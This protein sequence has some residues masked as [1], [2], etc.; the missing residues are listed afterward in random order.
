MSTA[1]EATVNLDLDVGARAAHLG[2]QE[3]DLTDQEF[4]LLVA[5]TMRPVVSRDDLRRAI[6]LRG[7]SP[8]RVDG[9]LVRLR[10]VL[11]PHAIRTVR[12]RGWML[13]LEYEV[14]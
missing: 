9:I 2:S 1:R 4:D 11:G 13:V 7:N 10:R 6:G 14:H 3:L 5:L 8:R 12:G